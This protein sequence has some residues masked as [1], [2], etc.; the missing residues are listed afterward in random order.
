MPENS[1]ITFHHRKARCYAARRIEFSA[2]LYSASQ[3]TESQLLFPIVQLENKHVRSTSPPLPC[4]PSLDLYD[5]P[6]P[7]QAY[8]PI[9][10]S[11]PLDTAG[12]ATH[13]IDNKDEDL[14]LCSNSLSTCRVTMAVDLTSRKATPFR[15]QSTSNISNEDLTRIIQHMQMCTDTGLQT[16]QL[17]CDSFPYHR[18]WSEREVFGRFA[19]NTPGSVL[20]LTQRVCTI[21]IHDLIGCPDILLDDN[22]PKFSMNVFTHSPSRAKDRMRAVVADS[23]R[24]IGGDAIDTLQITMPND[25]TSIINSMNFKFITMEALSMLAEYQ[26]EGLIRTVQFQNLPQ[27]WYATLAQSNLLQ[28]INANQMNG[29]M[30]RNQVASVQAYERD[31][32]CDSTLPHIV[33]S[34]SL[35]GGVLSD[36]FLGRSLESSLSIADA[37]AAFHFQRT[38]PQWEK[39]QSQQFLT[40]TARSERRSGVS[41]SNIFSYWVRYQHVL[42]TLKTIAQNNQVSTAAVVLRWSLQQSSG[43]L[44]TPILSTVVCS[45]F[46]V[47][48]LDPHD[49]DDSFSSLV[50]WRNDRIRSYRSVFTFA[51]HENDLAQLQAAAGW[52]ISC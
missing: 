25:S 8:V 46:G 28:I 31:N 21:P 51:L 27:H 9:S 37:S 10:F 12:T 48:G 19:S 26:R 32:P 43:S 24:R 47:G 49:Q 18:E 36:R 45:R 17:K 3:A 2:L 33:N 23:L 38:L 40:P 5:G 50:R 22:D 4:I 13:A 30:L 41:S 15:P 6:L 34:G 1:D 14:G 16:F 35:L 29:D 39:H 7:N 52:G 44:E 42:Q 20:R 11:R